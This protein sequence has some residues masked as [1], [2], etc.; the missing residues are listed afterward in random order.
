MQSTVIQKNPLSAPACPPCLQNINMLSCQRFVHAAHS[1][2]FSAHGAGIVMLRF[3]VISDFLCSFRIYRTC[4]LSLPVQRSSGVSHF[5]VNVPRPAHSFR[6]IC[7]MSRNLGS[8]NSLL[9]IFKIRKSQ[10]LRR[11][12]IAEKCRA[13]RCRNCSADS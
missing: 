8:D 13:G 6:D 11:C 7:R 10:V 9:Y 2:E 3:T 12:Y 5:I 1:T 4:P